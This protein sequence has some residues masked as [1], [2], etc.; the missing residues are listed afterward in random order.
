LFS[1]LS[2]LCIATQR[3][4]EDEVRRQPT[5]FR[6]SERMD[7]WHLTFY[8]SERLDPWPSPPEGS[9]AA[10]IRGAGP[11]ALDKFAEDLATTIKTFGRASLNEPQVCRVPCLC[12]SVVLCVGGA[13]GLGA[14]ASLQSRSLPLHGANLSIVWRQNAEL[15]TAVC[16]L[17]GCARLA[18]YLDG[19]SSLHVPIATFL[20]VSLSL[21]DRRNLLRRPQPLTPSQGAGVDTPAL[22]NSAVG[23]WDWRA[24]KVLYCWV[25]S[26]A[27]Y[28]VPSRLL[29]LQ[30]RARA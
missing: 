10:A 21:L 30:P 19:Y 20:D 22:D 18:C 16:E 27:L 25:H 1:L 9:P 17:V 5:A 4:L 13:H 2:A 28:I 6:F 15:R 12:C 3:A 23:G 29:V 7:P 26:Q 11:L 14:R 24:W 8:F